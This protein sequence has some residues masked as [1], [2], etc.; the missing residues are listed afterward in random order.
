MTRTADVDR[1]VLEVVY[2]WTSSIGPENSSH[3]VHTRPCEVLSPVEG[4]AIYSSDLLHHNRAA[5]LPYPPS[6]EP[7]A[8]TTFPSQPIAVGPLTPL[9][10]PPLRHIFGHNPPVVVV[11]TR[12]KRTALANPPPNKKKCLNNSFT[13]RQHPC[14]SR[15]RGVIAPGAA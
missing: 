10:L 1:D 8:A 9:L 15:G 7:T 6:Q 3:A 13:A 4:A 14:V 2:S 12:N 5:P 11:E